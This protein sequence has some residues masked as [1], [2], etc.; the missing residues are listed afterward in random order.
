MLIYLTATEN[1][2]DNYKTYHDIVSFSRDVLD[3]EATEII[4]EN[5]LSAFDYND[6]HKVLDLILK[7]MRVNSKLVIIDKD[8]NIIARQIF[9]EETDI[10]IVNKSVFSNKNILKSFLTL[11]IVEALLPKDEF[12]IIAKDFG[13]LNFTL[14]IKRS[15]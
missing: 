4:C 9:R 14:T 12:K 5:F 13:P 3:A 8:F 1:K 15:S 2:L 7:K 10:E 11:D 6:I